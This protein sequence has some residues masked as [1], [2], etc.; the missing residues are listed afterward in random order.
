MKTTFAKPAKAD[1]LG[2][3]DTAHED[4]HCHVVSQADMPVL[5]DTAHE[6]H[7]RHA[8]VTDMYGL[9]MSG[10]HHEDH[11]EH[12]LSEMSAHVPH[13]QLEEHGA[14]LLRCMH[15]PAHGANGAHGAEGENVLSYLHW[16]LV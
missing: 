16:I 11:H 2:R 9:H 15:G 8:T 1:M 12:V 6:D 4:H 10:L 3:Q 14:P 13:A 5:Q 7:E